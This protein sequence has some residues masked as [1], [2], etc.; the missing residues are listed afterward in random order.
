M[1]HCKKLKRVRADSCSPINRSNTVKEG[2]ETASSQEGCPPPKKINNTH[3]TGWEKGGRTEPVSVVSRRQ[4]TS[5]HSIRSP[6]R[7]QQQPSF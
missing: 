5:H 3:P 1:T 6:T 2:R 7:L 4:V